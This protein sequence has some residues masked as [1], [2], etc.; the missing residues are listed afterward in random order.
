MSSRPVKGASHREGRNSCRLAAGKWKRGD[1]KPM[2]EILCDGCGIPATPEHIARRLRHLELAT[3]FRPIHIGTLFVAEAPPPR[4]ENYFYYC[5]SDRSEN[6]SQRTGSSGILFDSLLQGVGIPEPAGKGDE[7]RLAEFQKRGLFLADLVECPREEAVNDEAHQPAQLG[8]I[9]SLIQR[10]APTLLKRI[11]FSYKPKYV[12]LI[13]RR[14]RHLIPIFQQAG[15]GDR[16]LL[17]RGLPLP[18]PHSAATRE[19]FVASLTEVLS[20]A[21]ARAK[22]A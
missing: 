1:D 10:F 20:K 3:R 7:V 2:T 8:E 5:V 18:F 17:D 4:L 12:A 19:R 16:L 9:E 15:L 22:G 13:S 6:D 11:Q 21:G 14:L